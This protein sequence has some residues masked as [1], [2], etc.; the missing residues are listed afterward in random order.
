[1]AGRSERVSREYTGA[2]GR[3]AAEGNRRRRAWNA[4]WGSRSP[5]RRGSA[6]AAPPGADAW[7]TRGS[8]APAAGHRQTEETGDAPLGA[9][10]DPDLPRA[11]Q[12][13]PTGVP[14]P[15]RRGT[16]APRDPPAAP[17]PHPAPAAAEVP[18]R[19]PTCRTAALSVSPRRIPG[20]A[21]EISTFWRKEPRGPLGPLYRRGHRGQNRPIPGHYEKRTLPPGAL[22]T[23]L[24]KLRGS[25]KLG[26]VSASAS[27]SL[28]RF[29]QRPPPSHFSRPPSAV[30]N[31]QLR[32]PRAPACLGSGA[33]EMGGAPRPG[34]QP[35]GDCSPGPRPCAAPT[36]PLELRSRRAPRRGRRRGRRSVAKP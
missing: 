23:A 2:G 20:A 35:C 26:V 1:M 32:S 9:L 3:F 33:R 31:P 28:V 10:R 30:S 8:A 29:P 27:V 15:V 25:S 36:P 6:A 21:P 4:G 11:R 12:R 16:R 34:A 17:R 19:R 13:G 22:R 14:Q 5:R 18:R 7:P 24:L